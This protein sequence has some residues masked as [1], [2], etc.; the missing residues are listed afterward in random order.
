VN[1]AQI[2]AAAAERSDFTPTEMVLGGIVVTLVGLAW[3]LAAAYRAELLANQS[4]E[5]ER[6][7]ALARAEATIEAK[8]QKITDLE[9]RLKD[10]RSNP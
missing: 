6:A 7:A 1:W 8:D 9:G 2:A 4:A 5:R 10:G 3:R